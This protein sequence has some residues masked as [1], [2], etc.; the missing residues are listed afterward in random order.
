MQKVDERGKFFTERVHTQSV[1]VLVRTLQG[2]VRGHFHILPGQRVK[3][4][5]NSA[6][7]FIALTEATMTNEATTQE[8]KFVAL[9]KQHIISLIP[10]EEDKKSPPK[11][12]YYP[13]Y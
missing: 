9:N 8:V 7:Q 13:S 11:D 6:D 3:D 10:L 1:Q 12:E 5:L 2:E 4:M